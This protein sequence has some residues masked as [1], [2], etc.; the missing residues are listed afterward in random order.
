MLRRTTLILAF[1]A[2]F[3]L[4]SHAAQ[5][6][7]V[8]SYGNDANTA[9]G[10]VFSNPCR[11][12][13]AALTVVDPGGEVVALDAAGYGAVVINKS[14]TL[15]ANPGF[16]AGIAAASGNAVTIATAGVNVTLRG[17]NI[18]GVGASYGVNMSAGARLTIENCVVSNFAGTAI[19]VQG[20]T[21]QVRVIDTVV[22]DNNYGIWLE[23]GPRA[24][25]A[26]SKIMGHIVGVL[27]RGTTAATTT[28]ATVSDSLVSNSSIVGV[29][30]FAPTA[31]ATTRVH[32]A[33][34]TI[35]N[36]GNGAYAS[37][38]DGSQYL[39]VEGSQIV[40]NTSTGLANMIGTVETLGNNIVRGNG[41]NTSGTITVVP[42]T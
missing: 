18:N 42:G 25:V 8:A 27:A 4:P 11:G 3:A 23:N 12:F 6:V 22:R 13:A 9:S 28:L 37:N 33:R 24:T 2:A 5:R 32:V 29:A 26:H 16:F 15:T 34:S 35:A 30:S 36:G 1:A 17:L 39:S 38:G 41:T 10:C 31:G 21:T 40:D 14:V 7:F 19:I 20:D